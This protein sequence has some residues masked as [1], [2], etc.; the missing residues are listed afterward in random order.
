MFFTRRPKRPRPESQRGADVAPEPFNSS[1]AA[2]PPSL[3]ATAEL[4]V[5][6]AYLLDRV[7]ATT[8]EQ[9]TLT[10]VPDGRLLVSGIVDTDRH[11]A[12]II[13]ALRPV[14]SNHSVRI[15][16][17][18]YNVPAHVPTYRIPNDHVYVNHKQPLDDRRSE[19]ISQSKI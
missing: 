14:S 18:D 10:G 12:E 9:V 1:S 19:L 7:D 17:S 6:V 4:E 5:E 2:N 15:V 3:A 11:K 13:E 8:G 16:R